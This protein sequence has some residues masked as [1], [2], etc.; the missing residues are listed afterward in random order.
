M[1]QIG[2]DS[3]AILV[4]SIV[5]FCSSVFD[6]TGSGTA[7]LYIVLEAVHTLHV[8]EIHEHEQAGIPEDCFND[9]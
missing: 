4:L 1:Y 9:K 6:N 5:L 2:E 7:I 8:L 3:R